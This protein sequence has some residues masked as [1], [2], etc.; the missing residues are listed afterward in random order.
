[1]N[2]V[3][4]NPASFRDP[5]GSI[6]QVDQRILRT[7]MPVAAADFDFVRSSGLIEKLINSGKL[8]AEQQVDNT[9]LG[10]VGQS[11]SYVLEHPRLAL[12]SYPYEWTFAAL[13]AAALLQLDIILEALDHGVM[14]T[15]ASAYNI[16][17]QGTQPIFIDHLAF[18]RYQPGEIWQG[19][20]Q[21]CEQFLN[22]LLLQ[23][24]LGVP[25]NHHYRGA[26]EGI[27]AAT[28]KKLLPF[29]RKII[30]KVFLHVVLQ[31]SLQKTSS[32]DAVKVLPK[33]NMPLDGLR[34]LVKGLRRWIS[35]LHPHKITVSTWQ[36]YAQEHT[37]PTQKLALVTEFIKTVQPNIVYDLG[38][39]T[40]IYAKTALQAG[41]NNVFGFDGDHGALE[42]A[43]NNAKS[44]QLNFLPLVMDLVDPSP[45]QGWANLERQ[46]F[47]QRAKADALFALAL[48]HHLAIGKN[49][50]LS[51]LI[52]W[53]LDIAPQGLLEF[54]PKSDPMVQ[55]LLR[56]REDIFADYTE[57]NF[58]QC[59]KQRAEI[60]KQV[61]VVGSERMLVWYSKK[62]IKM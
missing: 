20:R 22:P 59:I 54:V 17:F 49:I 50:P 44:E 11:A 47:T 3:M 33:I 2:D 41:A 34:N 35:G 21:F 46:S 45:A 51:Q 8:I 57:D 5:R 28:L 10:E 24:Y 53:L 6:Y 7:V 29:Y 15:D 18:R 32:S 16:Q 52:N 36:N 19:H 40:G 14:L 25:F 43:F 48:V 23:A 37:A 30:P 60:V 62:N 31:S 26:L 4:Q 1:M 55:E 13:K 61:R 39:N 58:L 12:I 27:T 38:C 9:I 42:Q 56:L